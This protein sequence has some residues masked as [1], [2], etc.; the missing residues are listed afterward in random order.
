MQYQMSTF[1]YC[2]LHGQAID[3]VVASDWLSAENSRQL[4]M[5][6]HLHKAPRRVRGQACPSTVSPSITGRVLRL[7][8]FTTA[9]FQSSCTRRLITPLWILPTNF[10]RKRLYSDVR[11]VLTFKGDIFRLARLCA[12]RK[13]HDLVGT[14]GVAASLNDGRCSHNLN[15][16]RCSHNLNDGRCSHNLSMPGQTLCKSG[17]KRVSFQHTATYVELL[18]NVVLKQ[19]N[20]GIPYNYHTQFM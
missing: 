6:A 20:H 2:R 8:M 12:H 10:I 7:Q 11:I 17:R 5:T 3:R 18:G 1:R 16:G 19:V 4:V 13:R 9:V 15:D 14:A